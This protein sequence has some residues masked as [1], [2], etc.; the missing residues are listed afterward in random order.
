MKMNKLAVI[1][2]SLFCIQIAFASQMK[3]LFGQMKRL[4]PAR[5]PP[6]QGVVV[7]CKAPNGD[8]GMVPVRVVSLYRNHHHKCLPQNETLD[9]F[10]QG[11]A[12]K[13]CKGKAPK[14]ACH[15][16]GCKYVGWGHS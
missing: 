5:I 10:I 12:Q 16:K 1:G 4:T 2:I 7:E 15:A 13:L 6:C 8:V 11:D 14:N 3:T 9:T